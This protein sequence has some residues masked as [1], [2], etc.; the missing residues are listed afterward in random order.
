MSMKLDVRHV[1]NAANGRWADIFS[2]LTGHKLDQAF[3]RVGRHVGCPMHGGHD[4][5]RLFRDVHQTGGAICN[6]CG[7]F[8]D[9]FALL[10]W[11]QGWSFYESLVAVAAHLGIEGSDADV[12]PE[13]Q[14][15]PRQALVMPSSPDPALVR[16][17]LREVWSASLPITAPEAKPVREY[18]RRR[19]YLGSALADTGHVRFHPRLAYVE[20]DEFVGHFPAMIAMVWD[21]HGNPAS[22]HRTYIEPDGRKAAVDKPK[23]L[24]M[25]AGGRG[26][27]SGGAIPLGA[28]TGVLGVSEGIETALSARCATGMTV[29]PCISA[30][31]LE[32]FVP[33]EGV[34][35]VVIWADKD[36][37]D[38]GQQAA[39][40][41]KKRL[42]DMGMKCCVM[43]PTDPIPESAKSVDWND[44]YVQRGISAFPRGRRQSVA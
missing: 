40:V 42:W 20:D 34:H 2:A 14:A 4:G 33:P 26:S 17:K 29:W 43:L 9:G 1:A 41:L 7:S 11:L 36:R 30:V 27:L 5:F 37:N 38:R 15:T 13:P 39:K 28:A 32:R 25:A 21:R 35:S 8:A 18:L 19:G 22:I 23:K 6:Q 24:M 31:L 12:V 10:E 44:V 16:M 3:E